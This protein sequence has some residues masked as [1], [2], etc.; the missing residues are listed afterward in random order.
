MANPT[1]DDKENIL[2]VNDTSNRELCHK[3]GWVFI[4]GASIALGYYLLTPHNKVHAESEEITVY[5]GDW[6]KI[7]TDPAK[8]QLKLN[9]KD[10]DH[11]EWQLVVDKDFKHPYTSTRSQPL[12][13]IPGNIETA[14][15]ALLGS[16][17]PKQATFILERIPKTNN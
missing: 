14:H 16:K 9:P 17:G 2:P 6:T 13:S 12:G 1:D 4:I 3:I 5:L 10:G 7:P 15:V 11:I 8:E